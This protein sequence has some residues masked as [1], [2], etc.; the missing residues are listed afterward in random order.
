M[1]SKSQRI[2][3]NGTTEC[4]RLLSPA[5]CVRD[6]DERQ[7]DVRFHLESGRDLAEPVGLQ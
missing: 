4:I 3:A 1:Q 7:A 5:F 2:I 6:I